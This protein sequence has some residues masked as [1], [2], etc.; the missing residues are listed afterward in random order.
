MTDELVCIGLSHHQTPVALRERICFPK[1]QMSRALSSLKSTCSIDEG[2]ILSTCNR[3]ELYAHGKSENALQSLE[4]FISDYH[5]VPFL[6]LKPHLYRLK[7]QQVAQQFFRVASSL[8]SLVIGEAQILGQVKDA[9]HVARE[10]K[11]LGPNLNMML[12]HALMTAKR[13]RSETYIARHSVSI[14]H[15]AVEL[16]EGVFSSVKDRKALIVGAG[17]MAEVAARCLIQKGA[18]LYLANRTVEKA[19]NL[20][21]LLGGTPFALNTLPERLVDCDIILTST[22]AAGHLIAHKQVKNAMRKRRYRPLFFVDIAVPRNIDPLIAKI[23]G[24]YVYNIDDLSDIANKR[25]LLRAENGVLA[26]QILSEELQRFEVKRHERLFG[27]WIANLNAKGHSLADAEMDKVLALLKDR[28]SDDDADKIRRAA[29]GIV[30]KL[31]HEPIVAIKSK[32]LKN[33]ERS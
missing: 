10:A 6:S 30:K 11:S 18:T 33:F 3:V 7:G 28:V 26:E 2:L 5:Q 15:I 14:S 32:M 16:I 24:A 12:N 21:S 19:E 29:H 13:I 8:D 20:A 17:A 23:D 4:T 27:P 22:N 1:E 25:L 31:L 9:I